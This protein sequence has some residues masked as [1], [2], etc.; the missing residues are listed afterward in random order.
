MLMV[1][2]V[3]AQHWWVGVD[4]LILGVAETMKTESEQ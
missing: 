4:T 2:P 3:S 1:A